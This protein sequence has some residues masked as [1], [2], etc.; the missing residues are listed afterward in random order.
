M[1]SLFLLVFWTNHDFLCHALLIHEWIPR[2]GLH[3]SSSYNSVRHADGRALKIIW[4]SLLGPVRFSWPICSKQQNSQQ[5]KSEKTR[6]VLHGFT[7]ELYKYSKKNMLTLLLGWL[8]FFLLAEPPAVS[9]PV[10]WLFRPGITVWDK[11]V[12]FGLVKAQH[13]HGVLVFFFSFLCG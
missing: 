12:V 5:K 6:V 8:R 4:T 13:E 9:D 11:N 3:Q 2:C 1:P 7:E 10:S